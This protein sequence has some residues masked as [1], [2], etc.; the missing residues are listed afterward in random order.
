[1]I[2]A[3]IAIRNV[4]ALW[5]VPSLSPPG[6]GAVRERSLRKWCWTRCWFVVLHGRCRLHI[7]NRSIRALEAH[8]LVIDQYHH[9][10]HNL[11]IIHHCWTHRFYAPLTTMAMTNRSAVDQSRF[12]LWKKRNRGRTSKYQGLWYITYSLLHT[13]FIMIHWWIRVSGKKIAQRQTVV[14]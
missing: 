7:L 2:R 9:I 3:H 11:W 1:M 5:L 8:N 12:T 6:E 4:I 14:V 13:W 10:Q